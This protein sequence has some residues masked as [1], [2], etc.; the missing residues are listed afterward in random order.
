MDIIS[1]INS[2]CVTTVIQ[3]VS[4]T[5]DRSSEQKGNANYGN[6]F[7]RSL[8]Y[9]VHFFF[10]QSSTVLI[11]R[12]IMLSRDLFT[13][14]NLGRVAGIRWYFHP[15]DILT[16]LRYYHSSLWIM[17]RLLF[18]ALNYILCLYNKEPFSY[19]FFQIFIHHRLLIQSI[20]ISTRNTELQQERGKECIMLKCYHLNPQV[21]WG[22][23]MYMNNKSLVSLQSNL[24]S[25]NI[26]L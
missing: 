16:H 10:W 3:C 14:I 7:G 6:S 18:S 20:N 12:V 17:E 15:H 21:A 2:V 22:E 11:Q 1:R 13:N 23:Y 19:I 25:E 24:D 4:N 26:Q 8:P 5:T 9:N